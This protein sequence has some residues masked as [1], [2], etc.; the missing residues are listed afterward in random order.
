[1][2][3]VVVPGVKHARHRRM[4]TCWLQPLWQS[5]QEHSMWFPYCRLV[6]KNV[7]QHRTPATMDAQY[8]SDDVVR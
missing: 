1:M 2:T 4:L 6:E 8:V 3:V 5:A 7:S